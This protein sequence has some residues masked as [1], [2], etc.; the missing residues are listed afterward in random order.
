MTDKPKIILAV[1]VFAV[2]VLGYY[3]LGAQAMTAQEGWVRYAAIAL[4]AVAGAGIYASTEQFSQF[5]QFVR[6]ARVELSRVVWPTRQETLQTTAVVIGM[7]LF[8]GAFLWVV[9]WVVFA[10]VRYLMG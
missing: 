3:F 7:V 4:G 10:A 5:R 9:D 6:E 2:G 8:V 1:A